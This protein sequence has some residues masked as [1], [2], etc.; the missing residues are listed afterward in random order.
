MALPTTLP[1]FSGPITK[2]LSVLANPTSGYSAQFAQTITQSPYA[3]VVV[4]VTFDFSGATKS[5]IREK[6][7]IEAYV[8]ANPNIKFPIFVLWGE[9]AT[10][11]RPGMVK[12]AVFSGEITLGMDMHLSFPKQTAPT[13]LGINSD[14]Y[15]DTLFTV[16]NYPGGPNESTLLAGPYY[17]T[18]SLAVRSRTAASPS[19]RGWSQSI[20]LSMGMMVQT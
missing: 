11:R 12:R 7:N 6:I 17:Y 2:I 8:Q 19:D 1:V 15:L 18:Y 20:G 14:C 4:P 9:N 10:P 16:L 13:D 3:G 5:F